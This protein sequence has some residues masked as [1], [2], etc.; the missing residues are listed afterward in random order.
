PEITLR[1]SAHSFK[2]V[3]GKHFYL[4]DEQGASYLVRP[5][6]NLIGRQAGCDVVIDPVHRGVSRKH[7]IIEP[8]SETVALITDIS[9]HG[10][11]LPE[12][13]F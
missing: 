7:L 4:V 8:V 10:T 9:S 1:L 3:A 6:K 2:L 12:K 5:G 13:F 11:Y